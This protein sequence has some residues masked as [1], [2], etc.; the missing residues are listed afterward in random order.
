M[1]KGETET[2]CHL[3]IAFFFKQCISYINTYLKE[4][5][6]KF[7][8]TRHGYKKFYKIGNCIAS[9]LD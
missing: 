4:E 1:I 7:R 5:K 9:V 8:F 2:W 6:K 3:A